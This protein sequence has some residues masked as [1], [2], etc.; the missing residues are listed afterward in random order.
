M[1]Y[2]FFGQQMSGTKTKREKDVSAEEVDKT[3]P[4]AIFE[5]I[6]EKPKKIY[7][8]FLKGEHLGKLVKLK[9]RTT[10]IGRSDKADIVV[11]DSSVSREHSI[12]KIEGETT[13]IEDL[14]STNGTF[15]NNKRITKHALE[16][17]DKVQISPST[18]FKFVLS[19]ESEKVFHEELYRMGVIDPV[20]N[21]YNKR[22]FIDRLKQ[23]FSY[24][25]RYKTNFSLLMIDID[26]FKKINDTHGHLAGDFVLGKISELIS[27]TTRREDIFA[28]YGGE[29]I[30]ALLPNTGEEGAAVAAERIRNKISETPVI[31]EGKEIKVTVSI[32]VAVLNDEHP[33]ETEE[34]FIKAADS[35]LYY[36]KEHG[37][38]RTTCLSEL[39]V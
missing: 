5:V 12:I 32:G 14:G 13:V 9:R 16:D 35:C 34:K 33:F 7:L 24:A 38:N 10:V 18:I 8:L 26:F 30:A 22:Y 25:I 36:S 3:I 19:D 15:V 17:S 2:N 1:S 29:E 27:S 31:F 11:N 28:R 37:R 20:T 39:K 23:E 4:K 6:E 21:L